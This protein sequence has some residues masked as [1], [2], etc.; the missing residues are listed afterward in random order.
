MWRKEQIIE[1]FRK[2]GKRITKQRMLIFDVILK[3]E[4]INC[5]E[6]YFEALTLDPTIG[7]STVYRTMRTMEEIGILKCGYRYAAPEELNDK[8]SQ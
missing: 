4:W 1:R 8:I 3:K 6:V 7:L 2:K 5:K